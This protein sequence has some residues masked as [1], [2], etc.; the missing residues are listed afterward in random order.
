MNPHCRRVTSTGCGTPFKYACVTT[1][2]HRRN[3]SSCVHA[4]WS[5]AGFVCPATSNGLGQGDHESPQAQSGSRKGYWVMGPGDLPPTTRCTA[6]VPVSQVRTAKHLV[7]LLKVNNP[8]LRGD[9]LHLT[10]ERRAMHCCTARRGRCASSRIAPMAVAT[11]WPST[12]PVICRPG[13][14]RNSLSR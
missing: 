12:S 10:R 7:E 9:G 4:P 2:P 3:H 6:Y 11:S 5:P 13:W 1:S 8:G 14:Y